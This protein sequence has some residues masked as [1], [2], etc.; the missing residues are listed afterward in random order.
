M[1]TP[2]RRGRR[3]ELLY[4]FTPQVENMLIYAGDGIQVTRSWCRVPFEEQ[5]DEHTRDHHTLILVRH[6]SYMLWNAR[7]RGVVDTSSVALYNPGEPFVG[8]HPNGCGD[9]GWTLLLRPDLVR[10]LLR[11]H[12]PALADSEAPAFPAP[13][14]YLSPETRL[15]H[16]LLLSEIDRADDRLAVEEAAQ[17]LLDALA[18][19]LFEPGA[20]P[21][22][23]DPE[24]GDPRPYV[25]RAALYLAKSFRGPVQLADVAR[26]SYTSTFHLCR[27]FKSQTGSTLHQYLTRLRLG[28]ALDA[29]AQP[30]VGIWEVAREVGFVSH[31]HF[32]AAFR[33]ELG[34]TPS[35]VRRALGSSGERRALRE[36][37]RPTRRAGFG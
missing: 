14:G 8:A 16:R 32:T 37:V 13:V 30:R 29:L 1:C 18:G 21:V 23:T 31:S 11:R 27:L 10:P 22:A 20:R 4:P 28:A 6:G 35:E 3:I 15:R 12:R 17:G 36:R 24:D 33:R 7:G 25:E 9:D 19:S 34:C 26:A 2:I 5:T